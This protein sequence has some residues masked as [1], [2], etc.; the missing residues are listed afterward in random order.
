M[1]RKKIIDKLVEKFKDDPEAAETFIRDFYSYECS[2]C[3]LK[4][5]SDND[6]RKLLKELET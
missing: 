5:F 6:L 2:N 3:N 4:L 1:T